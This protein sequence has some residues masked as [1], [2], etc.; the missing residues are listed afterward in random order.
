MPRLHNPARP[1]RADAFDFQDTMRLLGENPQSFQSESVDQTARVGRP[2]PFDHAGAEVFFDAFQSRG[3]N[4]FPMVDLKLL[5]VARVGFPETEDF[6]L[7]AFR[8]GIDSADHRDAGRIFNIQPQNRVVSLGMM[9]GYFM[10]GSL[11]R[12]FLGLFYH[13]VLFL[14]CLH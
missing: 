7:L 2:D 5:A 13:D 11:H 8:N 4:L 10:H 9:V 3:I 14:P 12:D 1:R 6:D